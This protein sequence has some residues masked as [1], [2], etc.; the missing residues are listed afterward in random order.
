MDDLPAT[1]VFFAAPWPCFRL[2]K[3]T[4]IG[5][6]ALA[7]TRVTAVTDP[8]LRMGDTASV[9]MVRRA[10]KKALFEQGDSRLLWK[11]EAAASLV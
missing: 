3:A 2:V 8:P 1:F 7:Q 6:F 11:G 4:K 5:T 9:N 10:C